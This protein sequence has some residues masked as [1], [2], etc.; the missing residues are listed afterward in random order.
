MQRHIEKCEKPDH[1]PKFGNFNPTRNIAKW[2]NRQGQ[3]QNPKRRIAQKPIGGLNRVRPQRA[4][5]ADK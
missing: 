1:P 5:F 2:R 3:Q 4:G